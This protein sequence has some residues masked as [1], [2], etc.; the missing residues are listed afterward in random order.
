MSA[1]IIF[2]LILALLLVIFTLQN[3]V[4]ISLNVFFWEITDVPLVLALL[5]CII[6][7]TLLAFSFAYP[8][9]WKLKGQLREKQK[10]IK[11]FETK[12][13]EQAKTHVEGIE[14]TD[15]EDDDRSFFKE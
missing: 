2:L 12:Q 9:I 3:T 14:I 4:L 1:G 15:Y 7:G 5:V 6:A 13:T 8:K 11:E 10:K